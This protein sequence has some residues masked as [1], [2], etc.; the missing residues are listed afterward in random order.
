MLNLF[1]EASNLIATILP[2]MGKSNS[3]SLNLPEALRDVVPLSEQITTPTTN[4]TPTDASSQVPEGGYGWIVI[5]A[6]AVLT[7]WFVGTTYSWGI[8][9]GALVQD[10]VS[11]A[12]TLSFVGALTV[13]FIAIMAIA[14]SRIIQAIGAQKTGVSGIFLLG[15]GELLSGWTTKNVGGLFATAGFVMGVGTSLCF[16][17]VSTVPAQS[18]QRKRGLAN[19]IVYAGGGLGGAVISLVMEAI[20]RRLGPAW[21]FRI[22][23]FL[24]LGTGI[25]AAW[26]IRERAPLQRW[27]FVEWSLFRSLRFD[28]LFAAGIIATFPLFVPPFFLPLF[29]QSIGLSAS[30]GA[31]WSLRSTSLPLPAELV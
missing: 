25:P 5:T 20:V 2:A 16:M 12:S 18:F 8:I 10:G 3:S 27:K 24:A 28:L 26:L 29:A 21:T 1:G 14:N 13:T 9:Q 19:G 11:Q 17:R 30:V 15:F 6:C 22:V 7:W 4:P 23:G 31:D